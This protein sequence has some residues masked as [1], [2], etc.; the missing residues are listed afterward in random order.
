[1]PS[2]DEAK[3]TLTAIIEEFAAFCETHGAAS[4]EDTRAKVIDR[5]LKEVC[6]WPE[7]AISREDRV[8]RDTATD[9]QNGF[10]DY[11][12]SLGGKP[13]IVVEAKREGIAF[14]FPVGFRKTNLRS[15]NAVTPGT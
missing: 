2:P 4:E 12:L 13:T 3:K 7:E 8:V 6:G 11:R 5:M 14:T 1:M 15:K 10:T 9:T